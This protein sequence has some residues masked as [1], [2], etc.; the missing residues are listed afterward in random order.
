MRR[1]DWLLLVFIFA[2]TG[3]DRVKPQ[4]HD[5]CLDDQIIYLLPGQS[6]TLPANI[7]AAI[8]AHNNALVAV[9]GKPKR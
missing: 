3:C 6:A 4:A 1:A 8:D 9:C 5:Y 2:L 7:I